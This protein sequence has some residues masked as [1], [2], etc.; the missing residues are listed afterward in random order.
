MDALAKQPLTHV[1][2]YHVEYVDASG[3]HWMSYARTQH[4]GPAREIAGMVR[5]YGKKI[6]RISEIHEGWKETQ[7]FKD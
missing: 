3:E 1:R 5:R 6:V 2:E 4:I 7:I